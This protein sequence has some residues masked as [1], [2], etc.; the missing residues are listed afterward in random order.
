[1]G[2]LDSWVRYWAHRGPRRPVLVTASGTCTWGDLAAR[3]WLWADVLRRRG[4]S[5][6]DHVVVSADDPG[7]IL[8]VLAACALVGAAAVPV[9]PGTSASTPVVAAVGARVTVTP[10]D[11][12]AGP[13]VPPPRGPDPGPGTALDAPL[14]LPL[15]EGRA[16]PDGPIALDH[17][18]V[19]SVAVAGMTANGLVPTDRIAIACPP[20]S[21]PALALVCAALHSGAQMRFLGD[22]AGDPR[23]DHTG[24][25][26]LLAGAREL[27]VGDRMSQ[28]AA[29]RET[30]LRAVVV[31][32]AVP[33]A[34]RR[35]TAGVA[36]TPLVSAS[37]GVAA[38]G[39]LNLQEPPGC[40]EDV[41]VPLLGQRARVVD[42]DREPS[43]PATEGTLELAG[44]TIPLGLRE[45]GWLRT[46][47]RA[48]M[49][50]AG[51]FRLTTLPALAGVP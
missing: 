28:V 17:A 10:D 9:G 20:A 2:S 50:R 51:R 47:D 30:A 42:T 25:T 15:P 12:P 21:P 34:L 44:S 36:G 27:A 18:N 39:G 3:S 23:L 29:A 37:Y 14:L 7:V 16:V 45:S 24:P 38:G 13:A 35:E 48:V 33:G 8:E 19:E 4:V 40:D 22:P 46:G 49:D 5:P 32:G 26:V 11:R 43:P 1:M 31:P 41:L 6:G